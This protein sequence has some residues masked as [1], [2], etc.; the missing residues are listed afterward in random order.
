MN[1]TYPDRAGI[2]YVS[3]VKK[4]EELRELSDDQ[5]LRDTDMILRRSP[6]AFAR[7]NQRTDSG[8]IEQQRLFAKW[9]SRPAN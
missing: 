4:A 9:H 5:A 7:A 8:L 3:T 2:V 1:E 6:D